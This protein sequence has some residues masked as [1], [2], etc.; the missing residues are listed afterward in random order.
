M[1]ANDRSSTADLGIAL[2]VFSIPVMILGAG[3][4]KLM[5]T[6]FHDSLGQLSL[7]AKVLGG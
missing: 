3:I 6:A 4:A 2:T 5:G 7:L 1:K